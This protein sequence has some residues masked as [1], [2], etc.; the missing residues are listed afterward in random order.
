M[1]DLILIFLF[2]ICFMSIDDVIMLYRNIKVNIMSDLLDN[3]YTY[4]TS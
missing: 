4:N 2:G 1:I 3:Q